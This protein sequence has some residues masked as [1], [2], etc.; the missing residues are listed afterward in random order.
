MIF[1]YPFCDFI[2]LVFYH[3]SEASV[4]SKLPPNYSPS[5]RID[6]QIFKHSNMY[7]NLES[8]DGVIGINPTSRSADSHLEPYS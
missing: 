7:T 6:P 2:Y 1:H 5:H 8:E 4:T 3:T